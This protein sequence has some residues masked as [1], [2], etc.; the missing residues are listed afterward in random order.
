MALD[1]THLILPSDFHCGRGVAVGAHPCLVGAGC[2][3]AVDEA[4]G[5]VS[6]IVAAV[7]D[8]RSESR[9]LPVFTKEREKRDQGSFGVVTTGW[10]FFEIQGFVVVWGFFSTDFTYVLGIWRNQ[11]TMANFWAVLVLFFSKIS[12]FMSDNSKL[13]QYCS[14]GV[15]KLSC[16]FSLYL[17][18]TTKL[19]WKYTSRTPN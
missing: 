5:E 15:V 1:L 12:W 9:P 2:P 8:V 19:Y 7:G 4:L 3:E 11:F 10:R 17:I 16:I 13:C 14:R 6:G 18:L